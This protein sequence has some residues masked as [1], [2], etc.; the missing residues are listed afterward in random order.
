ME[1]ATE[2]WNPELYQSSHS[3]VW[4]YGRELLAQLAPQPG[5]RILDVGC[6]TG[7]LTGEIS[8]AG[9][10]V[11]GIDSSASMIEQ[12]R[13]NFPDLRF[14]QLSVTAMPY[15]EEFDAVF[16]NATLHWVRDA[17]AAA[18]RIS[19]ALKPGGRFVAE[20]GGRGNTAALLE[21]VYQA[22]ESLGVGDPLGLNPWYYPGIGE[23]ATVLERAGL[24]VTF[25][26]LFDRPTPLEGGD[27]A[28]ANWLAM[29]GKCFTDALAPELRG[30]FVRRVEERAERRLRPDGVWTVD[31]RRLRIRAVKRQ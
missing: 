11:V 8:R 29:F 25:A 20:F 16:S 30:P 26:A 7:Q 28:L 22:L 13:Q 9:A 18:D 3:F 27:D 4:K 17:E 1:L 31:Y 14:E 23:Y 2:R 24:E 21:A 15:R 10:E 12:A 6:G 19:S 5:E